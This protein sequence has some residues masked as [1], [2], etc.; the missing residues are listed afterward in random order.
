ML[1]DG[2]L[3]TARPPS[4][5]VSA[6]A[7]GFY[8][9]RGEELLREDSRPGSGF[10]P[11]LCGRWEE[12]AQAAS[13]GKIRVVMPRIG[14]VLSRNGG[15]LPRMLF[16]FKLGLGGRIG[17]GRQ[18]MSWIALDD[19]TGAIRHMIQ[20]QQLSGPV[21]AVSPRYV[22]NGEFTRILAKA[23]SRPALFPVPA[24]AARIAFGEM[25]DALLLSSARVEPVRLQAAGFRFLHPELESAL[26]HILKT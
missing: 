17:S 15:A 20:N 2:L 22:T 19:L 11:D 4:V 14:L 23:L 9:D 8:G 6:S 10:L 25:A 18:F 24:F 13:A 26:S 5:L 16:P 21:N 12:A 1:V 7:I 3:S